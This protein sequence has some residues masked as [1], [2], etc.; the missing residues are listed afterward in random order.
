M[1]LQ[2]EGQDPNI[3]SDL[4]AHFA[5]DTIDSELVVI[6]YSWLPKTQSE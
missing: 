5:P 1:A 3:C 4:I 6:Q 2:M